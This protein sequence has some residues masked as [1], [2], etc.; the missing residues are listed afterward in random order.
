[1]LKVLIALGSI[2]GLAAAAIPHTELKTAVPAQH[3]TVKQ[4]PVKVTLTFSEDV[5]TKLS[6]ISILKPDSTEVEKL[7][8]KVGPTA[9]TFEG[10]VTHPLA[11]GKYLVR[12]KTV[13]DD[14]HAVRGAYDFTVAPTQ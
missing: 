4:S 8:V 12:W 11:A 7:V 6:T 5:N 10:A 13:S 9:A 2:G 1:M 3:G 14:G